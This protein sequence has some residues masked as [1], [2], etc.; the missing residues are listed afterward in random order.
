MAIYAIGDLHLSLTSGKPMDVF[1]GW[2]RY[3]ERLTENWKRTI[4]QEDTVVLCGDTSWGMSLEEA[5]ADFAFVDALPGQ[6]ILLKGNH[7]YWWSTRNKMEAFF[8]QEGFTTLRLLHNNSF[9]VEGYALCGTR[10]WLFER[11]EVH[12]TKIAAREAQRLEL[13]LRAAD[14]T[15]TETIAFLHYPPLYGAERS[16]EILDVLQR[17]QIGRCYYGH[18]HAAGCSGAYNGAWQGTQFRLISADHL[19]FMPLKVV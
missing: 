7:D 6:K 2:D 12:D 15:A 10:G 16:V 1:P 13:S 17:Y 14:P 4:T 8:M 19:R 11:G 9:F 3:V 18:I 5:R